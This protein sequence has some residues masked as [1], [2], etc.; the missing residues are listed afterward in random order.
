[1]LFGINY[2]KKFDY[3]VKVIVIIINEGTINFIERNTS[4]FGWEKG[5]KH[6][7]MFTTNNIH[8]NQEIYWLAENVF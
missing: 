6:I 8:T 1:M 3:I 7:K 4:F 5:E 2:Q